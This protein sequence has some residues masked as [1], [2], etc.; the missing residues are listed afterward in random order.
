M[1]SSRAYAISLLLVL[2]MLLA[3]CIGGTDAGTGTFD[4]DA[5]FTEFYALLGGEQIL[6]PAI[7]PLFQY[8]QL[9]CQYLENALLCFNPENA[10]VD[11]FSIYPLGG[12][13]GVADAPLSTAAPSNERIVDG[14]V[15]YSD[16]VPL[17]DQLYG[18]RYVGRPLTQARVNTPL[19]RV[20]QYFD[21]VGFYHRFNDA[22]GVV[23][24]LSYGVYACGTGCVYPVKNESQVTAS[25]PTF[26]QPFLTALYQMNG[27]PDF[28]E[29]L[30]EPYINSQGN[31]EQV[32]RNTAI[33]APPNRPDLAALR[34]LATVLEKSAGSP[35][36]EM[37]GAE[38][39]VVFI[40]TEG[41]LG[42]HVPLAFDSFI[43]QHGGYAI[44]GLPISDAVDAGGGV[45]RQCF[46]NFCLD[47]MSESTSGSLVRMAAL[48]VEYQTWLVAQQNAPGYQLTRS[49][50]VLQ[51]SEE[52]A[53][54]TVDATQQINLVLLNSETQQP[55]VNVEAILTVVYPDRSQYS[56]HMPPTGLDG[57][58]SV[59]VPPRSNTPNASVILYEVCLNVPSDEPICAEDTYLIWNN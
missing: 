21:N 23:H 30:G 31:W 33:S 20:E 4:L 1:S 6:G 22:P 56:V 15:I 40:A 9:S 19:E 58:S 12:A 42:Y 44:S 52:Y 36:P 53:S 10:S 41:S 50:V 55:M 47:Y 26:S 28:G 24:L 27:I 17:Y 51:L 5:Q 7:S 45:Y 16:F 37:Y 59:L 14:Y 48:G 57:S 39:G 49:S 3:A 2:G 38:D 25:L 29:A 8:N 13:M 43:Q 35:R 54:V 46:T 32:F 18:A 11:Q 34:P